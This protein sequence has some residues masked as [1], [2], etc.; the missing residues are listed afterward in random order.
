MEERERHFLSRHELKGRF[1]RFPDA[2]R[3]VVAGMRGYGNCAVVVDPHAH[4]I[5][6]DG[7]D[8]PLERAG[9]VVV[10]LAL[11]HGSLRA[12]EPSLVGRVLRPPVPC[13][14][15]E[16]YDGTEVGK[17]ARGTGPLKEVLSAASWA[18]NTS[19]YVNAGWMSTRSRQER[20]VPSVR[21]TTASMVSR[22]S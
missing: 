18:A 8:Q 1:P 16:E 13:G 5:Q 7:H 21:E 12:N 19:G 14:P 9:I 20:I 3:G 6:L 22:R 15:G 4:S 10:L 11:A 2:R 17:T